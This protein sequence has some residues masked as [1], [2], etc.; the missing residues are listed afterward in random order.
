[1]KLITDSLH[2][3]EALCKATNR[4]GLYISFPAF[5]PDE[6]DDL[7]DYLAELEGAAPYIQ[8][9]TNDTGHAPQTTEWFGLVFT[10]CAYLLFDTEEELDDL[11]NRTVGDDGPTHLNPYAGKFRVYACTMGPDGLLTENT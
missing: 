2:L 1:M 6:Y 8:C 7:K 3:L 11:Y 5:D 9:W 10:G 4:W